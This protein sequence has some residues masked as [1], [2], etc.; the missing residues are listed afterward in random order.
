MDRKNDRALKK[1]MSDL[2][3]WMLTSEQGIEESGQSNNH[4]TAYDAQVIALAIYTGRED[5]ARKIIAEVPAKRIFTQIEPDGTQPHEMWRTLS[6]GYSQYNLTHLIDIFLMAQKLGMKID[7]ATDGDG[8]NFYR[9]LDFM[10]SYLGKDVEEW[11]GKQI[12]SWPEKQQAL[13]RDLWRVGSFINTDRKDYRNAYLEHRVFNPDE[14]FTLLYYTPDDVDNAFTNA[15]ASLRHAIKRVREV[16]RQGDNMCRHKLNPRSINADSTLA[17]VH[18]H[19]WTSGFFPGELWM[20]YDF[21]NDPF[22]RQE[23][24]SF[25]WDIE[26]SK[27]HGGTHDLGFM[28]GDSFGKAWEITGEKSYFDVAHKAARTLS[29]RFNPAVGAIRSWDHNAA[30]WKFPVIIDNMMNLEMLFKISDATATAASEI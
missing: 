6:F 7:S 16:R 15:S 14:R 21:T 13:A 20:M 28:I 1:W 2:L 24:A 18:P 26:E 25:T 11:P 3:D 22:W 8:R 4:S 9:A 17:L 10:A 19:D 5:L 12:N 27:N 30:V 29:T 23:A